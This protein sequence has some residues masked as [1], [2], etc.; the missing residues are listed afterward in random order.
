MFSF[1]LPRK[2]TAK[3]TGVDKI[4]LTNKQ[5]QKLKL[6]THHKNK[7]NYIYSCHFCCPIP[8][9]NYNGALC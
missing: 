6:T 1:I 4:K 7:T 5:N 8:A 2:T 3:E 9:E